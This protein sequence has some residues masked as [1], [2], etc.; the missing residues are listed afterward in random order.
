MHVT[1]PRL[2]RVLETV[3]TRSG[4]LGRKSEP[5]HGFGVACAVYHGTYVAEVAEVTVLSSGLARLE[6]VWAVADPGPLVHPDGGKNQVEGGIQQAASWTLLEELPHRDGGVAASS[7]ADYPI[8]RCSDAPVEIDVAFTP[9]PGA[10]ST[11][12][13]EPGMVPTAAAIAN[14]VFAATSARLRK[15]PLSPEVILGELLA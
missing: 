5:G 8:A 6:R 2:R 9:D 3:R 1:D 10:P 12:L 7:F 15:L 11:G 13:G 14:A 4:W